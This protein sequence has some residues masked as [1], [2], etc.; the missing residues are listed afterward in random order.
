MT[1][2]DIFSSPGEGVGVFQYILFFKGGVGRAKSWTNLSFLQN[3]IAL[4]N[5]KNYFSP[6]S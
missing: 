5:V 3:I 1:S 4:S 2:A 6:S